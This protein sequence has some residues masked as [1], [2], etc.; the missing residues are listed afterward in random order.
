MV[1]HSLPHPAYLL[2]FFWLIVR[3]VGVS[4]SALTRTLVIG[5][6]ALEA[7]TVALAVIWWQV[8]ERRYT[9]RLASEARSE[10]SRP[11]A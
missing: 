5:L 11:G 4:P 9:Q 7:A 8:E 3:Y 1:L 2:L 10:M 6:A